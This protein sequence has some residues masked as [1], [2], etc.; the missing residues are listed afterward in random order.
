MNITVLEVAQML[1]E[2][3][4][5]AEKTAYKM[6]YINLLEYFVQKYSTN[7]A[8]ANA[9]L[10]LYIKSLLQ[11]EAD[12]RYDSFYLPA[13]AKEVLATKFKPFRW[14]TYRYCLVFDCIFINAY[15]E[16]RKGERI[17]TELSAFYRKRDRKK[18]RQVFDFLYDL[19]VPLCDIN[20]IQ[21][22]KD[23]WI[24]NR[25]FFG[26][27][28]TRVIVTAN[29]SAGKSTLLN[30]LVGKKVNKTQN[31]ACTAK[32]HYIVNKPFEDNL[33]YEADYLL[34]LDADYGTLMEDNAENKNTEIIVGTYFRTVG[35]TPN[36]VWYI[37]TP[38]VNSA[39]DRLHRDIAETTIRTSHADLLIYLM[40]GEN[41]GTDDDRKHLLFILQNYGG[42]IMFVVNKVDRFRK[43]EDSVPETLKAVAAE[44]TEIGF[45]NPF[46]VPVSAYAAYLAKMCIFGEELDEDEQE[47]YERM[48]RKLKKD[49]YQFNTYYPAAVQNSVHIETEDE[50][51]QLLMHSGI[52]QLETIIY[53]MR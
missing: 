28:P 30:A 47:E 41:I 13:L 7:D 15:K 22:M 12:Y 51:F 17:F 53:N 19:S 45:Q 23:C 6:K 21:Y 36:R 34:T 9:T 20:E 40:N 5:R 35:N 11:N 38:G 37:D 24:R 1:G 3:P 14:Y 10:R 49:E 44:L 4:I 48:S 2:H 39:Q 18:L 32:T 43:N 31:D 42:K 26:L 46:V 8:W 16:K 52:L 27:V 25:R 29:M 33:C 50:R